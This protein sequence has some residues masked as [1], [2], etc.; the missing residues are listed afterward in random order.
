MKLPKTASPFDAMMLMDVEDRPE[1]AS[2]YEIDSLKDTLTYVARAESGQGPRPLKF[3]SGKKTFT[4]H[5]T[6]RWGTKEIYI[7]TIPSTYADVGGN[8]RSQKGTAE[9][10]ARTFRKLLKGRDI[11]AKDPLLAPSVHIERGAMIW[12][13]SEASRNPSNLAHLLVVL[14]LIKKG[15]MT[16]DDAVDQT[17]SMRYVPAM[18]GTGVASNLQDLRKAMYAKLVSDTKIPPNLKVLAAPF[19]N[20][21]AQFLESGSARYTDKVEVSKLYP[22]EVRAQGTDSADAW[23]TIYTILDNK[24]LRHLR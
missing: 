5:Y 10:K 17:H 3:N 21:L 2:T 22:G 14:H 8:I 6:Q 7:D 24:I 18:S 13:V 15:L 20:N 9:Q 4:N 23:T 19:R 1:D 12:S 11:D 16:W